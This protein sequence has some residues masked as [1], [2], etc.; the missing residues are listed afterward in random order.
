MSLAERLT[1]KTSSVKLHVERQQ[2]CTQVALEF[3]Y[4]TA[5]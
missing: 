5:L 4:T 3:L 2:V 1:S